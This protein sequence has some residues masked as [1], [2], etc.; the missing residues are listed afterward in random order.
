MC[1]EGAAEGRLRAIPNIECDRGDLGPFV[2]QQPACE[3]NP[4]SR[5]VTHRRL[6]DE[7]RE[8]FGEDGSRNANSP[9]EPLERPRIARSIVEQRQ[10]VSG[11]RVAQARQPSGLAGGTRAQIA[12]DY[13]DE[14]ELAEMQEHASSARLTLPTGSPPRPCGR[15][16]RSW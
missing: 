2:R 13:L 14:Q 9:C 10:C 8:A 3:L 1:L 11:D 12:P 5:E 7:R 15:S 16:D 6:T 4:P